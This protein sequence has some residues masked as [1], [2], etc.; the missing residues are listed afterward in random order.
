MEHTKS[1]RCPTRSPL[2]KTRG[3]VGGVQCVKEWPDLRPQEWDEVVEAVQ[4]Y[5]PDYSNIL[6][7]GQLGTGKTTF[8]RHLAR[9]LGISTPITSPTFTIINTYSLGPT[10]PFRQLV[11]ADLYR[12]EEEDELAEL[13]LIEM[14]R[15]PKQLTLVEWPELL[16]PY[17]DTCLIL[18]I[19]YGIDTSHRRVQLKIANL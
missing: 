10:S 13:G 4:R 14:A 12:I 2:V 6:L 11:H 7:F 17:I 1:T 19:A 18:S 5:F 8:A 16:I 9:M 3:S 15:D